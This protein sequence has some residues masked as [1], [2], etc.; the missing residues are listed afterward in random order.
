M[1]G[2]S[3][4]VPIHTPLGVSKL[5]NLLVVREFL[6]C[7]LGKFS[8]AS[9]RKALLLTGREFQKAKRRH[10]LTDDVFAAKFLEVHGLRQALDEF[11]ETSGEVPVVPGRILVRIA[12]GDQIGKVVSLGC[13]GG[14]VVS[15]D[16]DTSFALGN[17]AA[18]RDV[19]LVVGAGELVDGESDGTGEADQ[20]EGPEEVQAGEEAEVRREE[21]AAGKVGDG[22]F[23]NEV[24]HLFIYFIL[25]FKEKKVMMNYFQ[26]L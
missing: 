8:R 21:E 26:V 16:A 6:S 5:Q 15:S 7:P 20:G 9:D 14:G 23:R 24:G 4:D 11:T 18:E 2:L 13:G 25:F 10:V 3:S 22:Q 1:E 12:T 17:G 19:L